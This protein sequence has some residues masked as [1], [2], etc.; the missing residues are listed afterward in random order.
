[1]VTTFSSCEV[2]LGPEV[3]INFRGDE[4]RKTFI[5][6]LHKRLKGDGIDAFIDSEEDAGQELTNFFKRIEK[7]KIALAVLSSRYTESHWCLQ[8]LVKIMECSMKG[9]GCNNKL[10]VI[11]ILYKL[12]VST[13]TELDGDFGLKLWNLWRLPGR[14]R[15]RDNRIVKWSEALE[16]VLS[17]KALIFPENGKE[18]DFVSTIVTHV[19]N[20]LS[21]IQ[22][23]RVQNPKPQKA[24]G[25]NPKPHNCLSRAS[26]NT[27]PEEQRLKQLEG[28]LNVECNDNETRI[29]GVVGMP[30]IGKTYL[31]EKL[32]VNLKR[33][34]DH[35]VFIKFEREKSKE[36]GSEWLQ[37]RVVENLLYQDYF[38]PRTTD[39]DAPQYWKNGLA[40]VKIVVILDNVIDKEQIDVFR[41]NCDWIKKG[42]KIVITT[43]DK[44]LIEGLV[45]DLYEVP[46]LNEG[47]GL[48]LF[49]AQICSNLEGKFMGMSRKFVDFAG[50]YPL[51][52]REFG[53]ELKGKDED[54]WEERLG[55]LT[56]ISNVEVG[57]FLKDIY[58]NDL[59]EKQRDAFLDIVCFFRSQDEN[60][61]KSLL[62]S[63][64]PNSTEAGREVRDLVDKFLIHISD[65]RIEMHNLLFT[66]GKELVETTTRKYWMLS[67]NSAVS[68]DALRNKEGRDEVRGVVLDM[69]KME[70]MPLNNQAFV[71]MSNL[72]YL[73]V[74][75]SLCPNHSDAACKLNL[76]NGIKFP[77][78]NI[79]RYI[80]WMNF[81]GEEFPSD[82]EPKDLI[83]LWLP[84]SKIIRLWD[85]AKDAPKLKWVNL[86]HS[87]KLTSISDLYAP[88]LLRLNLEGCTSLKELPHELQE[89]KNLVFLNLKGCTRLLYLPKITMVSLKTLILSGCSNLQ[90]FE[91]ISG[92]LE[93]LY[94]NETAID[95]LPPAIGNLHRL[96]FLNM[97]DCKNLVTLPDCLGKLK[98]LQ[99]LKL[100]RCS[101][102]K[103][104]PEIMENLRVL[105][106][107]GTSITEMPSNIINLSFVQRLCLS[108]NDQIYSLQFDMGH[109]F[110]LKWLEM[111]Y[112]KNL[113]S[114][115]RLPPNLQCLNA[116]GCTSLRTVTSPLALLK[117]TEQ[118]HSTFIFTNCH[119]LEQVSKNVIISYVQKKSEL[120]SDDRYNKDFVF[121]SL[122]STC[123][124]GCDIPAWFNH[125][126]LGS[127][128][129]LE[130]PQDWNAGRFIRIAL[131]VVVSF[132]E[133]KHQNN[134]L[135]V[136]CTCDFTNASLS[137]ESFVVGGWSEPGD[138]PHTVESDH[139]FIAYTTW[140]SIKKRQ[141]LSS[142]NEVSLRFEVTNGT[143]AVAECEVMKSGFSLVYEPEEAE[144][145]S[146]EGTSR[147]EKRISFADD[148]DF[149]TDANYDG[150]P[151]TEDSKKPNFLMRLFSG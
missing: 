2:K 3:F 37:K 76:P 106:L 11:P 133:Y 34:I 113:T 111:K 62:D 95:G 122:I 144:N 7:S 8:E 116:H 87:S 52:L 59:D 65:G 64:E 89:M 1:M 69:S 12:N 112:C 86:S 91:V 97:K 149:P 117:P 138:E 118:I 119:E 66:M 121:K 36:Q 120:M 4:L 13:V 54:Q 38:D 72:R 92:S 67:S 93:T 15:H 33:K 49:R 102:L 57:N 21:K 78:D 42:S 132:K 96:N 123:F 17:R 129:K 63:I 146:W 25:G 24:D 108:R 60:Y 79:V 9:E 75:N 55:T 32:F 104:F 18:D 125:Q 10:L 43:R 147:M 31:A 47:D 135:Q 141:Q 103:I 107:D 26:N 143:S 73:K 94:L 139:V 45:S 148:G 105:L 90:T 56:Q 88:N 19:K 41:G 142:A 30:G 44:S 80:Y 40:L 124:P 100:S 61:I 39:K 28:K 136:K 22:R 6:H 14:N 145:T 74:Y 140:S 115:P 128:L 53:V 70:E 130:L 35:C 48:E 151:T 137:P 71:G 27:E 99:E 150:T 101:K 82:F 20:A 98:S 84:Y 46:G 134:T 68:I 5:S 29:V 51:A 126:G 16:D 131:S 81:L 50:G 83:D 58:E 114:L 77:K 109:M 110:H 127:V 85:C 23:Q